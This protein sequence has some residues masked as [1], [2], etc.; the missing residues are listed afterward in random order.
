MDCTRSIRRVLAISAICAV[1]A[2]IVPGAPSAGGVGHRF[3]TTTAIPRST[4]A[5][6]KST[7]VSALSSDGRV[8]VVAGARAVYVFRASSEGSWSATPKPA[9]RL[10]LPRPCLSNLAAVATSS[11]GTTVLVAAG[12][13]GN[14][15][16]AVYVFHASSPRA[17]TG[18]VTP[19]ARLTNAAEPAGF[20]S[21]VALSADGR[22]ALIG[23]LA[24][25]DVFRVASAAAWRTS[26]QPTATLVADPIG[27]QAGGLS[28][29]VALSADGRTAL[30]GAT[31]L[32]TLVGAAYIFRAT[33]ADAWVSSATPD[34]VLTDGPAGLF[35]DGFGGAVALSPDGMTALVG[36]ANLTFGPSGAAYLFHA[37]P[38][39][40]VSSAT[41]DAVAGGRRGG[42][43]VPGWS[44]ALSD[45]GTALAGDPSVVGKGG[46]ADIL[47]VA[48]PGTVSHAKLT[49]AA[50][51]PGDLFGE[52]VGLSAD[53]T[54]A[55][56]SSIRATFIFVRSGLRSAPR[57]YVPY[58]HG[59]AVRAARRAIESTYCRVG[60]VTRRSGGSNRVISQTPKPG[61]RLARGATIDLRLS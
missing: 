17:W 42:G 41:P 20:G 18:A 60:K 14:N 53:G 40:W 6:G 43:D 33:A 37:A 22:T 48:R 4:L 25:A 9:A 47:H 27:A 8:A 31:N 3:W 2:A 50:S 59:Q 36:A 49:N 32:S 19:T 34:A 38:G 28:I 7:A 51:P 5:A 29:A 54:T 15:R 45:N 39:A 10:R 58:V 35:G 56:V 44:V 57:C 23:D 16:A 1:V 12:A 30:I 46:A 26:S 55:L 13:V 24:G 61:T 52:S 11:N 21:G